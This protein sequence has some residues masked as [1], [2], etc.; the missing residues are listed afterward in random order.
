MVLQL[1]A[2]LLAA[3]ILTRNLPLALRPFFAPPRERRLASAIVPM[4]SVLLAVVILLVAMKTLRG[5][6]IS[7]PR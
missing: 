3:L 2:L 4:A 1:V 6:L 7:W 5:G